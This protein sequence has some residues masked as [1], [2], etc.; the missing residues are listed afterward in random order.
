VHSFGIGTGDR[1]VYAATLEG[2]PDIA[3]LFSVPAD[4][5]A[6]PTLLRG[7]GVREF[8][9]GPGSPSSRTIRSGSS[10][11]PIEGRH[12]GAAARTRGQAVPHGSRQPLR[13]VRDDLHLAALQ[14][15]DVHSVPIAGGAPVFVI[16]SPLANV[17]FGADGWHAYRTPCQVDEYHGFARAFLER[18]ALDGTEPVETLTTVTTGTSGSFTFVLT[19]LEELPPSWPCGPSCEDPIVFS[20]HGFRLH[21]V[22]ADGTDTRTLSNLTPVTS[23]RFVE[24]GPRVLY[25]KG[26][27]GPYIAPLDASAPG[28]L[29]APPGDPTEAW[30]L[31]GTRVVFV[32]SSGDPDD[33]LFRGLY[34]LS[35]DGGHDPLLLN[36]PPLP[37]QGIVGDFVLSAGSQRVVF[38]DGSVADERLLSVPVD[39]SE[40][41]VELAHMALGGHVE[42]MVVTPDGS[43]VV[44]LADQRAD[45][46]FELYVARVDG[47]GEP[48]VVNGP[49]PTNPRA[50][51]SP[52][53]P[54]STSETS[55][56]RPIRTWTAPSISIASRATARAR[57]RG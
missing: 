47:T 7:P 9:L 49:L 13:P 37:G 55:S 8:R 40:P 45:D 18:M 12:R 36:G 51:S 1:V 46:V 6:P 34:S 31:S 35:I 43:R 26:G 54:S 32:R 11:F 2:V 21:A 10:P 19:A 22:D 5:S 29:L 24:D 17:R 3:G 23:L 33:G 25:S 44:Y 15:A 42:D 38:R 41:P 20:I 39:G 14:P 56:T 16:A 53:R 48:A 28:T 30:E 27:D 4:G 52:S 57:H 50:T